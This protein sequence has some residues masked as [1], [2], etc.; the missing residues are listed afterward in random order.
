MGHYDTFDPVPYRTHRRTLELLHAGER[1]LEVGC[2]SGALTEHV[3]ALGCAVVGVERRPKAAAQARSFAED[4]V[5]GDIEEMPL[6]WA[7]SSFDVI[8]LLDVL[9]HLVNPS[10]TVR[11]LLPLLKPAGRVI[12]AVPNVAHWSIRFRLLCGRFDYEDSGILDRTHLHLYTMRTARNMLTEGGL[13][14]IAEDIVPDFPFLRYRPR[15]ARANYNLARLLPGLLSTELLFIGRAQ[16]MS[17][18]Q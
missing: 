11:R 12:V 10:A 9:E 4:V 2:S 13:E 5:V 8:L 18:S 6:P 3:K 17:A 16:G 14:L 1:V 7:A 15:W